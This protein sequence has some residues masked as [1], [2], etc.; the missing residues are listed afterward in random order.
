MMQTETNTQSD[1]GKGYHLFQKRVTPRLLV[2][3]S[4]NRKQ[5]FLY[6][7]PAVLAR[8]CSWIKDDVTSLGILANF[9]AIFWFNTIESFGKP[10]QQPQGES[11]KANG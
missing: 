5:E 2:R 6:T 8:G 9:R 10:Q 3:E 11:Y 1:V 4:R 7:E